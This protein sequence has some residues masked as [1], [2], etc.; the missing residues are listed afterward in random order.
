M[1][2]LGVFVSLCLVQAGFML[3]VLEVSTSTVAHDYFL[4]SH[5][6]GVNSLCLYVLELKSSL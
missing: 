3:E 6:V 1:T 5:H 4:M 2:S